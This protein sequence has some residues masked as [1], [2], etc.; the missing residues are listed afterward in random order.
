MAGQRAFVMTVG[1]SAVP[2]LLVFLVSAMVD[3]AEP[4]G[5]FG[6]PCGQP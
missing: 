6:A 3:A 1:R 2:A 4:P 5:G